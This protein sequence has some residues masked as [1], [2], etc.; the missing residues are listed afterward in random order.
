M[1]Q[2]HHGQ[3][4]LDG[5]RP[6]PGSADAVCQSGTTGERVAC[7]AARAWQDWRAGPSGHAALLA[8]Y[9]DGN[10]YEEWC[11]D[12]V[13]YLY[14]QA[15]HPFT[16]GERDGWDEYVADDIQNQGFTLHDAATY[17][18]KAGDVA[19][20]DYNGGHVEIVAVGGSKPIFIYGD[21]GTP[22][23][24]TGN[25]DMAENSITSDGDAGQVVYYLSPNT[26]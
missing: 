20:F 23:P 6:R 22:D 2:P 21:S 24:A 8:A 13:S 26:S 11:A 4:A 17:T 10:A 12:F 16:S 7:F 1:R 19:Y 18:P 25:G 14:K 5:R 9:T 3:R 15:G